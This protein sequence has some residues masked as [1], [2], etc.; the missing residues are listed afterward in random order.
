M[1]L[2]YLMFLIFVNDEKI[3]LEFISFF[4]K[5]FEIE[6]AVKRVIEELKINNNRMLWLKC[7]ML[8]V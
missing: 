2:I 7:E 6:E 3:L 1:E 4:L 5:G 8:E